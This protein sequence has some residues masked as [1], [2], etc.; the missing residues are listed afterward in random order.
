MW[1]WLTINAGP[2]LN[3][4]IYYS[5]N[6][7]NWSTAYDVYFSEKISDWHEMTGY[8]L[9]DLRK[10]KNYPKF[11]SFRH[12]ICIS[13]MET[14][15]LDL[16]WVSKWTGYWRLNMLF[17]LAATSSFK[18]FAMQ[19]ASG[20]DTKILWRVRKSVIP[21]LVFQ[22]LQWLNCDFHDITFARSTA[23]SIWPFCIIA[24]E[25]NASGDL[26]LP[27]RSLPN[28]PCVTLF[29][30]RDELESIHCRPILFDFYFEL[31][32]WNSILPVTMRGSLF[33]ICGSFRRTDDNRP[34][35]R[36]DELPVLDKL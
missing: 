32:I 17:G 30:I 27:S 15:I 12:D 19:L 33:V 28:Q 9:R 7:Q 13:R 34:T 22:S 1:S 31:S 21:V 26:N 2:H 25:T 18:P 35:N 29:S 10:N 23:K 8:H 16:A 11:S 24:V 36:H 20:H 3:S 14:S 4:L 5:F 6:R